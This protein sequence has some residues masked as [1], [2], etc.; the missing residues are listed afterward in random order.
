MISEIALKDFLSYE[1]AKVPMEGATS[2]AVVGD[3][4]SGKSSLL[5]AIPYALYGI[6]RYRYPKELARLNGDGTFS[7]RLDLETAGSIMTIER[8]LKSTG[9]V[10]VKRDG[11]LIAKGIEANEYIERAVGMNA[12]TFMLTAFFGLGDNKKSDPL[13]KVEPSTC[14]DTMQKI[15][16][17][18][19]YVGLNKAAKKNRDEVKAN[20][21]KL[22]HRLEGYNASYE[23]PNKIEA[24]L[25]KA[26]KDVDRITVELGKAKKERDDLVVEENRSIALVTE[27][28]SIGDHIE[29]LNDRMIEIK[30][31]IESDEYSLSEIKRESTDIQKLI[32]EVNKEI[33]GIKED[34]LSKQ[35]DDLGM[36]IGSKSTLKELKEVATRISIAGAKCPLCDSK[37][38]AEMLK[39]W[40]SDIEDIES[41]MDDLEAEHG[42]VASILA[43]FRSN[44][45]KLSSAINNQKNLKD[46][47]ETCKSTISK[48]KKALDVAFSELEKLKSR[49]DVLSGE[50]G[51]EYENLSDRINEVSGRVEDLTRDYGEATSDVKSLRTLASGNTDLRKKIKAD[52]KSLKSNKDKLKAYGLLVEAFSRYGIPLTLLKNLTASIEDR[53]TAIYGEFGNGQIVIEETEGAKPGLRFL[54]ADR[55]GTRAFTGLSLGEQ[56]MFFVAVRVAVAQIVSKA[57]DVNLNFLVLDEGMANLSPKNRDNLLR[58]INKVLRKIFAQ[59]LM[60]SHIEMNDIFSKTIECTVDNDV[61]TIDIR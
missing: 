4:G 45:K 48:N 52:E 44:S 14:L 10:R 22:N 50:L 3:N 51:K 49:R 42:N 31:A 9:F 30:N 36:T 54:L 32:V 6:S 12:E 27:R 39:Q 59:V 41:E 20:I 58:L 23:D 18:H 26:R 11:E 17:V 21:E 40:E 53:A 7:V 29:S 56:A 60:V 33:A 55:K 37:I 2:I 28:D 16:N 46:N 34:D 8:G 1:K 47:F 57:R 13:L 61:T 25:V 38:D 24:R 5:E 35:F 43:K 15:A 19:V